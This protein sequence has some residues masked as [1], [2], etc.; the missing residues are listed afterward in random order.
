MKQELGG[1]AK[2]H[3]GCWVL[4]WRIEL[5]SHGDIRSMEC[6]ENGIVT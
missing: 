2:E 3:P 6:K 1:S 4:G 5:M